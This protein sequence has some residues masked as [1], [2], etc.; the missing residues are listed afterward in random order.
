MNP[1]PPI[2]AKKLLMAFLRDDLT[3]EVLG[4]LDEKFSR[5]V[6]QKALWR[7]KVNY[8]FQVINYIRPFA[9]KKNR[10]L[11][12]NNTAMFENYFK[13]GFRNLRKNTGYSIINIGGLAAGMAV[14]ILI[15]LWVYD[16]LSFDKYHANYDRIAQVY[17]HQTI[18]GKVNTGPAL[19]RPVEMVLRNQY[20]SDFTYLSMSS[21]TNEHLLTVGENKFTKEG[22]F[23]QVDFPKIFS[24]K[25][26]YG[27]IDGLRDQSSIMLS[28]STASAIFG[29]KDP[30]NQSI[31]IDGKLDVKVTGV[32]EDLPANTTLSDQDFLSSW[33]LEIASEPWRQR[34][35]DQWGN[36]SFQMFAQIAPGVTFE[37]VTEK[38]KKIK[39]VGKPEEARFNPLIILYPMRDWHLR[40][41]WKDGNIAG[42]RIQMVWLFGIIGVFVVLLACINFMNLSTARSEKRAKEVGIRMTIGSVR[43]QLIIQF[44]SESF[45]VVVLSFLFALLV[46]AISFPAFNNLADKRMTIDWFNPVFWIIGIAFVITTSL[47]AGS[48]PALYLSSFQPVKILKGSFKA[49]RLA[50][51]PRKV[52]V[53]LQFT[54]SVTLIIGTIVVY[55]QIQ[56]AKNRPLGYDQNGLIMI[57]KKSPEFFGKHD[58]LKNELTNAGAVEQFAEASSPLTGIWSNN[59]GFSWDGKDPAVDGEFATIWVTHDYGK[60]VGW[61]VVKGR[62]YSREFASDSTALV[63]NEAAEK[64]I[65]KDNILG[66]TIKWGE[67]SKYGSYHVIGVV[68][69]MVMGNPYRPVK[70]G[71]YFLSGKNNGLDWMIMKLSP[72]KSTSESLSTV[73]GIFKKNIP[74]GAFDY[75]FVDETYGK[76]FSAE[77][78]VGKLATVFATFAI[79]ISCL[80][81]FGLASFVTEQRTKEIGVRKVMGASVRSLWKMLSKDF[82]ILVIISCLVAV[83]LSMYLLQDWLTKFEYRTEISWWVL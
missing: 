61:K 48:Y 29:D 19:P 82:V 59:G 73:E 62:D 41:D 67:G 76:K 66:E 7:A 58:V 11:P 49:G 56:F 71:F 43:R 77:E 40:N 17:Q 15:G 47:L 14:A 75:K 25:M 63:I 24:L 33:E 55:N 54:I 23:V 27:V 34:A 4:D 22:S 68:T 74:S 36:N 42:G 53:V 78:R 35:I 3:E 38:I 79:M 26:K 65:G 6:T 32:Y 21:W 60:A 83:P 28:A 9:L 12:S 52:L 81:L 5:A 39:A 72:D 16:E 13:V 1:K 44:L 64:F 37:Q 46:V 31:L 30:I 2:L 50:S 8:W 20:G 70:P 69:D 51:V 10:S 80:G 57:Q 18:N 45:L